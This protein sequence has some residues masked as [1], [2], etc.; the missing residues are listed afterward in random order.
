MQKGLEQQ[1]LAVQSGYWPLYRYNPQNK[2]A[3]MLE[4]KDPTIPLQDFLYSENRFRVLTQN[5]EERAERLL[6]QAQ[7][8][9]QDRLALYHRLAASE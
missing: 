1:K 2:P 4:S 3:L 9:L 8:D 7:Q 6:K 5:D